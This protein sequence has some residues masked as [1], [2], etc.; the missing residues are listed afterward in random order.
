MTIPAAA[1][2][3]SPPMD[4]C[5]VDGW[6]KGRGSVG[7]AGFLGAGLGG[8]GGRGGRVLLLSTT[9]LS[10]TYNAI[11]DCELSKKHEYCTIF[12]YMSILSIK[13]VPKLELFSGPAL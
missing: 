3:I 7:G 13:Q 10:P 2:A 4:P 6:S 11:L 8:G 5:D 12:E 9:T 1:C